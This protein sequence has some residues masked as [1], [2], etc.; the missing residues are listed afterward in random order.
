M[1][2]ATLIRDNLPDF[3][4]HA[5]LYRCNPPIEDYEPWEKGQQ[6][7]RHEYII[8]SATTI[9]GAPETYLFPSNAEGEVVAWGELPG[10]QKGTL[11]H[12]QVLTDAGYFVVRGGAA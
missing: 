12:D 1:K 9:L 2:T 5:A 3:R 10:S 4:G 7:K 6:Q 11:S 8:A